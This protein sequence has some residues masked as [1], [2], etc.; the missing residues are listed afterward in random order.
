MR[1]RADKDTWRCSQC[2]QLRGQ[3]VTYCVSCSLS[4]EAHF[5]TFNNSKCSC[6]HH[7]HWRLD[8]KSHAGTLILPLLCTGRWP[9]TSASR[10]QANKSRPIYR[11]SGVIFSVQPCCTRSLSPWFGRVQFAKMVRHE[12]L[13]CMHLSAALNLSAKGLEMPSLSLAWPSGAAY[14]LLISFRCSSLDSIEPMPP[15]SLLCFL[16]VATLSLI[17][18]L[19]TRVLIPAAF[20]LFRM[21]AITS[22]IAIFWHNS[23]HPPW[24]ILEHRF[25][26]IPWLKVSQT[27]SSGKYL[28]LNS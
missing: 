10:G 7:H 5:S 14:L 23:T 12:I 9:L 21:S 4:S 19:E 11:A 2:W 26:S 22:T 28:A 27:T 16:S 25:L 15:S 1:V 13:S 3:A 18:L 8:W 20:M 17:L 6:L 24:N